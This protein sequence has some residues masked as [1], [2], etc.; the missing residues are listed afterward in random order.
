VE[1]S[2]CDAIGNRSPMLKHA[3]KVGRK[4]QNS[5]ETSVGSFDLMLKILWLYARNKED[6][7]PRKPLGPF[8]TDAQMYTQPAAS[9][10]RVTW[11]GHSSVL[12]EMDGLRVLIDPM[13]DERT[14]PLP[15]I[16]PKRFFGCPLPI[17]NLPRI[18][19]VLISH[20]H[21]DHLGRQTI[22]KLAVHDATRNARWITSAGVGKLLR[23]FGVQAEI[24]E[25]DWTDTICV[26]SPIDNAA[27]EITA[28]PARHFSGRG[29]GDRFKTLWSSLAIKGPHH[30]IY[31]GAD[32]GFWDGFAEIGQAFG[33]FDLTMLDVGAY[34]EMWKAIHMGPE[35]AVQAFAALGGSGLLM[36]IHWGL[37]DL[38]LHSWRQ[39]VER[40]G[41]LA[42]LHGIKLWSPEL[43]VPTEVGQGQELRSDWWRKAQSRNSLPVGSA[44]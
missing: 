15:W 24:A 12:I 23:K 36:P 27:L 17:G 26:Q 42:D 13:W 39:P 11:M 25:L 10:L 34:D 20:D 41:E 22:S 31:F 16:G 9:G 29:L 1:Q 37:F 3:V 19:A 30:N 8:R 5:V 35:G 14:S 40:M 6:R 43:G 7:V 33:P 28:L 38:A 21:Y 32:S 44:L 2:I 18:D 4:Y